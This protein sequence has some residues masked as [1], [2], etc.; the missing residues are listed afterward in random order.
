M[1]VFEISPN[2]PTLRQSHYLKM[3]IIETY[4][5]RYQDIRT[6]DNI[7]L[8]FDTKGNKIFCAALFPPKK[9]LQCKNEI[10]KLKAFA[11]FEQGQNAR[12]RKNGTGAR[13]AIFAFWPICFGPFVLTYTHMHY[14]L[15]QQY[16]MKINV[17][18]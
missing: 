6:R 15:R 14:I 7:N 8:V 2:L 10:F 5:P 18:D 11:H 1:Q 4:S 3:L 9:V 17:F 16:R 13:S 12:E